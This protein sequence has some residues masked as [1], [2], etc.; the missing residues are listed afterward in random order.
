MA[1]SP[2]INI[3]IPRINFSKEILRNAVTCLITH[4]GTLENS[5]LMEERKKKKRNKTAIIF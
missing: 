5:N 1:N 2:Y 3:I 4:R